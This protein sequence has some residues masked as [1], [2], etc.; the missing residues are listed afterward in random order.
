MAAIV[1]V[2][3]SYAGGYV[4]PIT[5]SFGIGLPSPNNWLQTSITSLILNIVLC[6]GIVFLIVFLNK[7]FNLIH[8][9]SVLF[10]WL[11]MVMQAAIPVISGQFYSGTI[12]CAVVAVCAGILFSTFNNPGATR[13]VFIIFLLLSLGALTQYAYAVYIPIFLLG[14][15]QMRIFT[16]RSL[17]AAILGIITPVWILTGFG[18]L[19]P[20]N[21]SMPEFTSILSAIRNRELL[22]ISVTTGVTLLL[23]LFSGAGCILRTYNY[24]SHGRSFNGFI[25]L[26]SISTIIMIFVNYINVTAYLPL[27]NCCT[28]YHTAHFFSINDHKLSYIGILTIL[29][30]YIGMYVWAILL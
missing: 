9:T 27:L 18:I 3:V 23:C 2:C 12:L 17:T 30:I 28:A 13:S 14:C 24:N 4:I 22:H 29:A 8:S 11:F 20:D 6:C 7:R 15:V 19:H 16:G 26:V 10:A 1:G 21:F 5:G 25:Y